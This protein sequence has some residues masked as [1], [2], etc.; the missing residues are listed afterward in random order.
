[1]KSSTKLMDIGQQWLDDM[2]TK[3]LVNP[4]ATVVLAYAGA[5][6]HTDVQR[7]VGQAE[8]ASL[9]AEDP[10]PLRKRMMNVLVE[11]L[12]NVY[13]HSLPSHREA[14]F[15][16]VVRDAAGY[17]IAFGNAVPLA[18]AAL[19]T[20][21]VGILNEMDEADLKEHYLKLLS[22][23]ARSEHGGAGLG[24]LTMA[25]KSAKPIVVRTAKLCAEAAFLTLELQVLKGA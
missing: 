12:E 6:D 10:M 8:A 5:V 18:M 2:Q 24:L 7:L 22:N 11:G 14:A 23:S 16:L 21:R 25:R 1:M 15:L 13:H 4:G 3:A 19:I 20:H 17:R 9:L